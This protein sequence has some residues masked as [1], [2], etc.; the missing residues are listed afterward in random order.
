MDKKLASAQQSAKP[1]VTPPT[2]PKDKNLN[3]LLHNGVTNRDIF[4]TLL[5][6]FKADGKIPIE[7]AAD[8]VVNLLKRPAHT[9]Y[10]EE[11]EARFRA[12]LI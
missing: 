3:P 1:I 8:F 9:K 10:D 5:F 11:A 12:S 7:G 6:H 4:R 2:Q